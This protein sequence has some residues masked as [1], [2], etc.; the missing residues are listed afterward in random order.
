MHFSSPQA[1]CMPF[2]S[3]SSLFDL[4]NNI[5]QRIR[6]MELLIAQFSPVSRHSIHLRSRYSPQRPVHNHLQFVFF[7]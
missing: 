4:S 3:Y 1:F 5:W 6:I 2:E 7:P